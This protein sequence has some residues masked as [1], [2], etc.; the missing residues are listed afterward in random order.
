MGRNGEDRKPFWE[1]PPK[2]PAAHKMG[3]EPRPASEAFHSVQ[4][5]VWGTLI[6]SEMPWEEEVSGAWSPLH[7]DPE[8]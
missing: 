1:A 8:K 5:G 4:S 3:V 7:G 6:E 2:S